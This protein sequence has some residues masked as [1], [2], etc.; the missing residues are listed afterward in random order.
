MKTQDHAEQNASVATQQKL[1]DKPTTL[2]E[3]GLYAQ[4]LASALIFKGLETERTR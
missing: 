1:E 2:K 3:A 4:I